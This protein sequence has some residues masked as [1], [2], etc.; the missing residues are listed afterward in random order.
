MKGKLSVIHTTLCLTLVLTQPSAL[1][2]QEEEV[3]D[4]VSSGASLGIRVGYSLGIGEWTQ[5]RFAPVEHLKPGLTYGGDLEIR[6]SQKVG[7]GIMVDYTELDV[8]A[9]EDYA[10]S[11][12][13]SVRATA[14]LINGGVSIRSYL[15]RKDPSYVKLEIGALL[16]FGTGREQAHFTYDYDFLGSPCFGVLLGLEYEYLLGASVSFTVKGAFVYIP[17]GVSYADGYE[18]SLLITP[19]TGGFRFHL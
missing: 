15:R 2:A 5:H 18:R 4:S 14:S 6:L 13:S 9:W 1:H 17:S 19:L 10:A 3:A 12:G 7:L 11:K 16:S 8:G